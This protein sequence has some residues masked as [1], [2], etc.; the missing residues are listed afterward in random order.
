MMSY[1]LIFAWGWVEHGMRLYWMTFLFLGL[2]PVTVRTMVNYTLELCEP[3]KHPQYIS[4]LKVCMAKPFILS[5]LVGLLV[6]LIG[7]TSV[8]AGIAVLVAIGGL[9]TFRLTEPRHQLK[10]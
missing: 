9:R 2:V 3:E 5:P 10:G 1:V 4:I 8:F 6:D 7:F